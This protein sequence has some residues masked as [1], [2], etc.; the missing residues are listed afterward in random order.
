MEI[1]NI[2]QVKINRSSLLSRVKLG[3]GIIMSNRDIPVA[4]LIPFHPATNRRIS[5]G[6]D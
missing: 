4:Q 5:L 3:E 2:H 1:V 6:Q